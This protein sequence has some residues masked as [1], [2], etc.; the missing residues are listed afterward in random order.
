[1]K[2]LDGLAGG[3]LELVH[4]EATSDNWRYAGR[5]LLVSDDGGITGAEG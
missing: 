5:A 1:M 4:V 3:K 2:S